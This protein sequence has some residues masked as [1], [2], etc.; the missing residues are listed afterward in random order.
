YWDDVQVAEK[1]AHLF[2]CPWNVLNVGK[3]TAASCLRLLGLKQGL[4]NLGMGFMLPFL[5]MIRD[6]YGSD[7]VFLTGDGGDKVLPD[8]M[9]KRSLSGSQD[10]VSYIV[11]CNSVLSLREIES[12]TDVSKQQMWDELENLVCTY[13]ENSW[14]KKYI[15]FLLFQR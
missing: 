12:L 15:H 1:L 9:P 10:L 13:P 5:Q 7:I 6:T 11:E 2:D 3:V 4:N 14:N 8:L